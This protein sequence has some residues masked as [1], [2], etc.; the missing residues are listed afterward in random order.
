MS[1]VNYPIVSDHIKALG[2]KINMKKVNFKT[3]IKGLQLTTRSNLQLWEDLIQLLHC[4]L[5]Q[6]KCYMKDNMYWE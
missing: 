4:S 2:G 6:A 1:T 5:V 3:K